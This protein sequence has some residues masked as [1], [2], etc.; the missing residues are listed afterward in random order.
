M[1]TNS[2]RWKDLPL[3]Q[4]VKYLSEIVAICGGLFLLAVNIYQV[5]LLSESNEVSR[6]LFS[7]TFPLEIQTDIVKLVDQNPLLV[8]LKLTNVVGRRIQL[9]PWLP[10]CVRI[11][12]EVLE[13]SLGET[14][15]RL[16]NQ[17]GESPASS[18]KGVQKPAV[19]KSGESCFLEISTK[20]DV[21]GQYSPNDLFRHKPE[22][23]AFL[24]LSLSVESFDQSA[25]KIIFLSFSR[26]KR[27]TLLAD[28]DVF[29]DLD[30]RTLMEIVKLERLRL[31]KPKD[32]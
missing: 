31:S 6:Q 22:Q 15:I 12:S 9:R 28:S 11:G 5:R 32:Y 2:P 18:I 27:G 29:R 16:E 25:S 30:D 20:L 19:L 14:T 26:D 8:R 13:P 10:R 23:T 3:H 24:V 21:P 17:K 1:A 7:S 4:R